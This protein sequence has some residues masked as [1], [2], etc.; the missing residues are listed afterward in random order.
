MIQMLLSLFVLTFTIS[1]TRPQSEQNSVGTIQL[2]HKKVSSLIATGSVEQDWISTPPTQIESIDCY[3]IFVSGSGLDAGSCVNTEG[4]K[5]TD[6]NLLYGIF[7]HGQEVE[8]EFPSGSDRTIGVMGM[9]SA[10]GVC[11][12]LNS[13]EFKQSNFTKPLL[14][15]QVTKSFSPGKSDIEI[16]VSLKDAKPIQKC[17][18]KK[19][20]QWP[21]CQPQLK[22]AKH[23][24]EGKIQLE[25]ECLGSAESIRLEDLTQQ[26]NFD[27]EILSRNANQV[28]AQLKSSVSFKRSNIYQLILKPRFAE[29]STVN[30]SFDT[31]LYLK[32]GGV[33]LGKYIN[34]QGD[35]IVYEDL[36]GKIVSFGGQG[37]YY[38]IPLFAKNLGH[39]DLRTNH[40]VS[41]HVNPPSFYY[42]ASSDCSG[43]PVLNFSEGYK[44]LIIDDIINVNNKS[45]KVNA[46]PT[47]VTNFPAESYGN[48]NNCSAGTYNTSGYLFP[49]ANMTEISTPTLGAVPADL[50]LIKK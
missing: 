43:E 16:A 34:G 45:Y 21:S 26:Q 28:V 10:N 42:Y 29:A 15:G 9:M 23:M 5:V 12:K 50:E 35:S 36:N 24:G 32:S 8:I 48:S 25:G 47:F 49:L 46:P 40:L 18:G 3:A 17:E 14:M 4:T 2:P 30:L 33:I 27:L 41:P 6:A 1:C 37:G 44:L 31:E 20:G 19:Y 11:P 22:L 38:S 7:Q 13:A 39:N